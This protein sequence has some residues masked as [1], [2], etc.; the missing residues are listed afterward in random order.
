MAAGDTGL[1]TAVPEAERRSL[2]SAMRRR[3]F[4]KG[5]VLF[6]EGDPGESLHL[7]TK[8]RAAISVTTPMGESALLT[9]IGPGDSFGEQALLRG[10][11]PPDRHRSR[12]GGRRDPDAAP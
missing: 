8:G 3:T 1:L 7:V 5:D 12:V 2:A 9:V 4:A 6:Y 11:L 10:R